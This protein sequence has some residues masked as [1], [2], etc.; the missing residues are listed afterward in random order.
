MQLYKWGADTQ[1]AKERERKGKGSGAASSSCFRDESLPVSLW[2][3]V[4]G[5][6]PCWSIF[7][8]CHFRLSAGPSFAVCWHRRFSCPAESPLVIL[9]GV[10]DVLREE[11][12]W[13]A[14]TDWD[15]W[16]AESRPL[17]SEDQVLAISRVDGASC[18]P[19]ELHCFVPR[20]AE[21]R[22]L[23]RSLHPLPQAWDCQT[24]GF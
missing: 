18:T 12:L 14:T 15:L 17:C 20:W 6:S 9:A 1:G 2:A 23:Q 3:A 4:C 11:R 19:L 16:E 10:I 22:S 7:P 13:E 8:W 21:A 24:P 5:Q